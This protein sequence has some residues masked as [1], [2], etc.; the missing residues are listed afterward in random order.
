MADDIEPLDADRQSALAAAF[1]GTFGLAAGLV[2]FALMS[3][4]VVDVVG[5]YLLNAPL[6]AGYELIQIG[7][8]LIVFAALPVCTARNEQIRVEV[9]QLIFPR[10][11][12]ARLNAL[13]LVISLVVI[14]GFVWLLL[15]RARSF[16]EFE[17]TTQNLQVPL[18]PLAVFIT[19]SWA[20]SALIVLVQLARWR[21]AVRRRKPPR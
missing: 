19:A 15:Q 11:L 14:L 1:E 5:R 4:T 2:L 20:I 7:M 21:R 16:F 3:I 6:P 9:F 17:E 13:S 8:A 10:R 18:A 12:R